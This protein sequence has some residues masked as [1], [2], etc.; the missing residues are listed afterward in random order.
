MTSTT[1]IGGGIGGFTVASELRARGY[2]GNIFIIDPEGYPY[3]RPPLSKE[4]LSG[5]KTDEQLLLASHDWYDDNNVSIIRNSV[6]EID[7]ETSSLLLDDGTTRN[8]D[9]LV[10]ATGGL[11]RQLPAPGFDDPDLLVLRT[12]ADSYKLRGL[13]HPGS[14]LVIIGAG[15]IG[16]EVASSAR[17]LGAEVTLVDP[18]PV[19]LIP[20][21]GEQ[22]ATQLHLLHAAHGVTYICGLT[23]AIERDNGD[24]LVHIDGHDTLRANAVLLAVGIVPEET[25]AKSAGLECDGGVLVNHAQRT[26]KNNIWAIGDCARHRHRDGTLERRHE[27]WESAIFEARTAAADICGDELPQHGCSWF[28]SDRYGVHVEGA[29][30][31]AETGTTV[32]RPDPSGDPQVAFLVRDDGTLAGCAAINAGMAVRAAR[33]IIDKAIVVD[34]AQLS[35]PTVNLK[36]LAR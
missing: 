10:L 5:E 28:W 33:R 35:D 3:D 7:T 18:T 20:A 2:T 32:I 29:G 21:V 12:L 8:F 9:K 36:K 30:S 25:L 13:L 6:V 31:L 11:P 26:T 34:P 16:A 14:H 24:F 4:I 17:N 22:L 15:L 19:A 27:H 1:I 23:S